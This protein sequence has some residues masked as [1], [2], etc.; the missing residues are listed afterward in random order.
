MG[1]VVDSSPSPRSGSQQHTR[2]GHHLGQGLRTQEPLSSL[3]ILRSNP[4]TERLERVRLER[5]TNNKQINVYVCLLW[6]CPLF[7]SASHCT[8]PTSPLDNWTSFHSSSQFPVLNEWTNALVHKKHWDRER[9]S[10]THGR[11]RKFLPILFFYIRLGQKSETNP[12][13]Q[14]FPL[15]AGPAL[16]YPWCG[17]LPTRLVANLMLSFIPVK[18]KKNTN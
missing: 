18:E 9:R 16:F 11:F 10:G 7:T 12:V 3:P 5:V 15:P 1:K 14:W 4:T 13:F 17:P 8:H 6:M 2:H